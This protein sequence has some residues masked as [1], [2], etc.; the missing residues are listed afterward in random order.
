MYIEYT[1]R[2]YWNDKEKA[3]EAHCDEY[4]HL[5]TFGVTPENACAELRDAIEWWLD[6]LKKNAIIPNTESIVIQ[7]D[8]KDRF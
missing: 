8:R 3:Y 5:T 1:V 6:I 4:E 7:R 2:V